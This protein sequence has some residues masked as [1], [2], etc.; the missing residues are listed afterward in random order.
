M[1]DLYVIIGRDLNAISGSVTKWK[2]R[3]DIYETPALS[4]IDPSVRTLT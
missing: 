4:Q 3:E 1:I 2:E